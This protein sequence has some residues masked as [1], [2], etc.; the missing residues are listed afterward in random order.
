MTISIN[1]YYYLSSFGKQIIVLLIEKK[2]KYYKILQNITKYLKRTRN[3]KLKSKGVLHAWW[4]VCV[5]TKDTTYVILHQDS[6]KYTAY[7]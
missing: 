6:H 5:N 3:N 4:I 7:V 2:N 1:I